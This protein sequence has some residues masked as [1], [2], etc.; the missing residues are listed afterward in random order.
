MVLLWIPESN[1][2]TVFMYLSPVETV[3]KKTLP[4]PL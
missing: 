4:A 3:A 1:N 2:S